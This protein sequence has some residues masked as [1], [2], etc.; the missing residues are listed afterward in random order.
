[1]QDG[2][3]KSSNSVSALKLRKTSIVVVTSHFVYELTK[4]STEGSA[5]IIAIQKT[6]CNFFAND[7]YLPKCMARWFLVFQC[8]CCI[9]CK[10]EDSGDG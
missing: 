1:V 7:K 8:R 9:Y 3:G 10:N 5:S 4:L 2:I 6:V